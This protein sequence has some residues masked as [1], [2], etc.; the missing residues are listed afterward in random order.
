MKAVLKNIKWLVIPVI[1]I[2]TMILFN[3]L[4]RQDY[5]LNPA[6]IHRQ[7]LLE[8]NDGYSFENET[9]TIIKLQD[10]GLSIS[11][12]GGTNYFITY[13]DLPKSSEKLHMQKGP[14]RIISENYQDAVSMEILLKGMGV[15]HCLA[16]KPVK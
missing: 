1:L 4:N 9:L 5:V 6:G 7:I 3:G 12:P 8:A 13:D 10:K 16:E 2:L 15:E 11:E 14:K